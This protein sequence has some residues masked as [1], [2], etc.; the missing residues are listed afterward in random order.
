MKYEATGRIVAI[1]ATVQRSEKFRSREFVLEITEQGRERTFTNYAK[2]Q[3]VQDRT[4]LLDAYREGDTVKVHFNIRGNRWERNGQVNY[5]TN[6]D[7]WKLES[8][9]A[10]DA[11]GGS[12]GGSF[13]PDRPAQEGGVDDLPF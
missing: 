5:I 11:S 3:L 9:D 7:A 4:A 12:A 1:Y 13:Q 8:A 10:S 6:L 2:F